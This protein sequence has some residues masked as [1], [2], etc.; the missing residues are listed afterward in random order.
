M[1]RR[2]SKIIPSVEVIDIGHK[3]KAIGKDAEGKVY[4]IDSNA[5]PGDVVEFLFT[6]K[7]K[8]MPFGRATK[9]L[10]YSDQRIKPS[11][12]HFEVCGGCQLQN[13]DYQTQLFFK[14]KA[15]KDAI[16]KIGKDDPSKV[17]PIIPADPQL[18]YRNKLKFGFANDRWLTE[19]EISSDE[20]IVKD[21]ALGFHK[22]GCYYKIIDIQ[23]CLLQDDLSNEIRNYIRKIAV[24]YEDYSFFDVR[25]N[26]GFLRNLMIR[27]STIGEW[28]IMVI[29]G[30]DDV[31]K[32]KG[33]LQLI[34]DQF[35]MLNSIFYMVNQK[36]NDSYFDLPQVLFSG[37][38]HIK[39]KLGE[40]TFKVGP[41]SFFQTNTKQT[42]T[43]Y[44]QIIE[45]AQLKSTDNVYDLYTGVGSIAL[46]LA[47]HCSSV[48]GIETIE[49]AI[50]DA[51][52]NK[53]Y[54]AIQNATFYT[55]DVK[56]VLQP[57]FIEQH[58]KP[59]VVII[60]PPREGIHKKV[61]Q[62]LLDMG[63]PRLV[64]V[65]C[66]PST[67]ARDIEMLSK[68]YDLVQVVPVDMFPQTYHIESIAQLS[69]KS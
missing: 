21:H 35:P 49:E 46:Y 7:K 57:A 18:R 44:D 32:I 61:I 50:D 1:G 19:E 3:G 40:L 39:E 12:S 62:T 25:Q 29:F 26:S 42:I 9:F 11:C 36:L 41:K 43:L 68:K 37:E 10:K 53:E 55:G 69:L 16:S 52:A 65:S 54:N 60:D 66:N 56:D 38:P 27:N 17:K 8:G 63:C 48:V 58:G 4:L 22:A 45:L 24:E 14:E 51:N 23:E 33:F 2:K 6:R 47:H 13:L 59:D 5:V 28:M 64:Y 67:Q 34:Q 15:V 20:V 30:E 31:Q